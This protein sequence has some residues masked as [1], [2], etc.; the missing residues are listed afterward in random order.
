MFFEDKYGVCIDDFRSTSD[1]DRFLVERLGLKE[2]EVIRSN[3][4]I[5]NSRTG[6]V[7]EV[8]EGDID[9]EFEEVLKDS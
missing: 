1:V 8:E 2:L 9:K 6:N 3:T 7:L 4:N 5:S